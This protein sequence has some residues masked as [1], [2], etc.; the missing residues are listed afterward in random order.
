MSEAK[1][2]SG[3]SEECSAWLVMRSCPYRIPRH[4]QAGCCRWDDFIGGFADNWPRWFKNVPTHMQWEWARKDWKAG[5]TGYEAAHNA[6]RRIKEAST[7]SAQQERAAK[8]LT[9]SLLRVARGG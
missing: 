2:E 8:A 1:N 3:S 5:N 7:P 4:T 6:Q 9:N